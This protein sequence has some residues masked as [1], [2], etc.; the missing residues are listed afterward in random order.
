M[1]DKV[2]NYGDSF[3][4]AHECKCNEEDLWFRQLF[5][6]YPADRF[7]NRAKSGNNFSYMFLEA[8][9]DAITQ[10]GK[11]L[12]IV[13]LGVLQRLPLYTDGW[14][15]KETLKTDNTLNE[16]QK[17]FETLW[18]KDLDDPKL[19][20]LYHPT[21]LYA[22]LFNKVQHLNE[23]ANKKGNKI[24]FVNMF[25]SEKEYNDRHPLIEPFEQEVVNVGNYFDYEH[26]CNTVC[27]EACIDPVDSDKYGRMGHHGAEGQQRFAHYMSDKIKKYL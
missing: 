13:S 15:D 4:T 10:E 6:D 18:V 11:L 1:F 16:C 9:H 8:S 23:L 5:E 21:L 17:Y 20:D 22:E 2:I 19:A 7:I 25:H 3:T 24:V 14:Y 12:Q 27:Y 26:S